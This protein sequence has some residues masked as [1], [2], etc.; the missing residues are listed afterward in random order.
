MNIFFH[1]NSIKAKIFVI[2]INRAEN[3]VFK[4]TIYALNM[5][6]KCAKYLD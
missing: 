6:E 1:L 3:H 4:L 2:I 5:C